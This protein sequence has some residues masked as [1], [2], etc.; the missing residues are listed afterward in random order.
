MAKELE[1]PCFDNVKE[2]LVF[3]DGFSY[4]VSDCFISDMIFITYTEEL[5][6]CSHL[7]GF[8]SSFYF[9]SQGPRF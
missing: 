9:G 8:N 4:F 1:L 7:K 5:S 2:L 6:V 3:A